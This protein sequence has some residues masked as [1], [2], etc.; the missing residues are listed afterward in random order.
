MT[1]RFDLGQGQ[2]LFVGQQDNQTRLVLMQNRAGQQQSQGSQ[3]AT[4]AW[5]VPPTLFR[6]AGGHMLRLEGSQG[7]T[8]V[9]IQSGGMQVASSP[10]VGNAE[11]VSGQQVG[12][13]AMPSSSMSPM[14]P[15]Q[16]MEP[17]EPMQPMQPM[18]PMSMGD[19]QMQMNPMRMQM[20]NMQMQF[21]EQPQN[22]QPNTPPAAGSQGSASAQARQFCTQCGQTV[23]ADDRFCAYCGHQLRQS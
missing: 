11:V 18:Q 7:Q 2:Q 23:A 4:G 9:Q 6:T 13:E 10:N 20:G 8:W 1:Y 21:D 17:M 16:P 22:P 5:Q 19:M 15:M 3:F 12:D 14:Q